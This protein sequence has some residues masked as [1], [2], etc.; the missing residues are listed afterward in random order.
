MVKGK[1]SFFTFRLSQVSFSPRILDSDYTA[2]VQEYTELDD[3][4]TIYQMMFGNTNK[5]KSKLFTN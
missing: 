4:N 3:F 2:N 1:R 5:S